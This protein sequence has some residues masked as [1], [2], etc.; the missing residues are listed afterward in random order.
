VARLAREAITAIE[1]RVSERSLD[2]F[3]FYLRLRNVPGTAALEELLIM[4]D[5]RRLR[6]VLDHLLENAMNYSPDGG[7]IDVIV[8][9]VP[10]PSSLKQASDHVGEAIDVPVG[11][12]DIQPSGQVLEMCVCDNGLGIPPEHLDRIFERFHRVDTSLTR[13]VNG[14]GLGLTICKRIVELHQGIIWAES[15]PSG[16]S[17]FHVWLPTG[18]EEKSLAPL[19]GASIH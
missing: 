14:L 12:T 1:Q 6:E 19:A 18:E 15:C 17:A 10:L 5:Q 11:Q 16:G 7:A 13:E 9:F 8:R 4:A 3:T 2:R